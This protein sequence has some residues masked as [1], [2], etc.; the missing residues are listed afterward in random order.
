M[1]K[2]RLTEDEA[3]ELFDEYLDENKAVTIFGMTYEISQVLK[4]CDPTAYRV[5]FSDWV[6][7]MSDDYEVEGYN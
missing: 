4:E 3:L 1:R 5:T 7:S 6:D 2:E